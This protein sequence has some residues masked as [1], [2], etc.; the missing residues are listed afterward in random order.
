VAGSLLHA[1][2]LPELLQPSLAAYEAMA[3]RLSREPALLAD[4]K[5]RLVENRLT[6]PLFDTPRFA[7]H[8]EAA[9]AQM[10]ESWAA[11]REA[12]GFAVPTLADAPPRAAP[13]AEPG[14]IPYRGCPLCGAEEG[15]AAGPW[16]VCTVC[17]HTHAASCFAADTEA[18]LFAA[19]VPESR[20]GRDMEAE[21][22]VSARIVERVVRHTAC[23][24]WLDVGCGTG[25]LLFTAAEFG[26]GAVA[27]EPRPAAV[28]MLRTLGVEAHAGV[29]ADVVATGRF[30]VV[31]I[32]T[33]F[34]R[35]A[36]PREM[37]RRIKTL[38]RPDGLVVVEVPNADSLVWKLLDA[39][40]A[41]PHREDPGLL[42]LY[43]RLRLGRLLAEEGLMPLSYAVSERSR[44]AMEIIARRA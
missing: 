12:H 5:R 8:L 44:A 22:L 10:W 30:A 3:L 36:D 42:H 32:G 17:G 20:I 35:A 34:S 31:S 27:L 26:F 9:F 19:D 11:G 37:L 28:A 25:S 16:R 41:N 29:L 40:D 18:R 38:L 1:V 24:D 4:L 15:P 13:A 43:D 6:A 21:R 33:V 14:R 7:R 39:N 23:G 2:G